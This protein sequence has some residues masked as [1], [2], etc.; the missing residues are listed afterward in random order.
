MVF[1]DTHLLFFAKP[2]SN[3]NQAENKSELKKRLL[4]S[5]VAVSR[6]II[7]HMLVTKCL[8]VVIDVWQFQTSGPLGIKCRFFSA[9]A[10]Q[11]YH[12]LTHRG[13]V[14]THIGLGLVQLFNEY[15]LSLFFKAQCVHLV[16]SILFFSN[17]PFDLLFPI[18]AVM[19]G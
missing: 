18:T 4:G 3:T 14:C 17:V 11:S 10:K 13:N 5:N 1:T 9:T 16:A 6:V 8:D 12:L 2:L 19:S 15:I 7:Y